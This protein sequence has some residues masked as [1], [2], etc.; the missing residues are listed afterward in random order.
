MSGTSIES[1]SSSINGLFNNFYKVPAYQRE[2]VWKTP[3]VEQFLIDVYIPLENA[4][5]DSKKA[6]EYFIG[7]IVVCPTKSKVFEVIDGQQRLTTIVILLSALRSY[8]K[9]KNLSKA[10][11]S[12][13]KNLLKNTYTD[14]DGE[15]INQYRLIL[16]YLDSNEILECIVD[17]GKVDETMNS[18]AVANIKAAFEYTEKFLNQKFSPNPDNCKR[19]FGYLINKVKI[20]KISTED[21]SS[22]LM[23]FETINQRGIG[24]NPF[25][26]I[27]NRLFMHEN[28]S[29]F[30][31]ITDSWRTLSNT[32][33]E[34]KEN[35]LRFMRYYI[36]SH[37]KLEGEY[38]VRQLSEAK[39]F[40]WFDKNSDEIGAK[41]FPKEYVAKLNRAAESYRAFLKMDKDHFN[42]D[43]ENHYIKNLRLLG[44]SA[45]RQ[46]LIVLLAASR[47][48]FE[49]FNR[50]AQEL[51]KCMFISLL[52]KEK[53]QTIEFNYYQWAQKIR[54][55]D[56]ENSLTNLLSEMA[57][58]RQ[59]KINLFST[60]FLELTT[61][62]IQKFRVKY[63]LAKLSQ[64][65]EL[66]AYGSEEKYINLS[67]YIDSYEIEHIFPKNPSKEAMKEFGEFEVEEIVER[68]GNLL[69]IEKSLNS[70]LGNQEY[71]R[72]RKT[73]CESKLLLTSN[74][75]QRTK[76]GKT[77]IDDAV[78]G[79][80]QFKTW[81][82]QSVIKRQEMLYELAKEVWLN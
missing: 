24:L 27:K 41:E 81:N 61:N 18:G 6:E 69:L 52:I 33:Y 51:E 13:I 80:E 55:L 44:G 56:G 12:S 66:A 2:Y 1:T 20:V 29:S 23:L 64:H 78:S 25:D 42:P 10:P 26:L 37:H 58:D 32:L 57:A 5:F 76:I 75:F 79:L 36:I 4:D 43:K 45:A 14:D 34:M 17:K 50:V 48:D 15:E 39:I 22:A 53:S 82:E 54:A 49:D 40:K 30:K 47:L 68:I 71:S 3:H 77:M 7:S 74:L 60:F 65:L 62:D 9:N 19:F 46:H 16:Q 59:K 63:I 70:Y 38:G 11:N 8:F 73:Y 21:V 28:Q 35:P 72:K 31:E 67:N